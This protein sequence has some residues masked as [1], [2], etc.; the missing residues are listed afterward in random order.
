MGEEGNGGKRGM[1]RELH[2]SRITAGGGV[3][4]KCFNLLDDWPRNCAHLSFLEEHQRSAKRQRWDWESM[5]L[6]TSHDILRTKI[7]FILKLKEP[8]NSAASGRG[9]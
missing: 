2:Y 1:L 6:R 7:P 3:S 4:E 9:M 8:V 5:T